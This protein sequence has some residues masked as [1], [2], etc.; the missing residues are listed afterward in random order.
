MCLIGMGPARMLSMSSTTTFDHGATIGNAE[1]AQAFARIATLLEER[2]T[3]EGRA[4]AY[5]RAAQELTRTTSDVPRIARAEGTKG[6]VKLRAIGPALAAEIME[7]VTAGRLRLLERLEEQADPERMLER[8]H[9]I[10]P[11]LAHRIADRLHLSTLEDLES[12]AHNGRLANV[13]GVGEARVAGARRL[14]TTELSRSAPGAEPL[15][16]PPVALLL[17]V[18]S[19]YR[20]QAADGRIKRIAPRRF[21]P[22]HRTWLAVLRLQRDGWHLSAMFSNTARAHR[23]DMTHDWVVIHYEREGKHGQCT[24]VTEYHGPDTG[25]RVIRG[26]E[27][28]CRAFRIA[29]PDPPRRFEVPVF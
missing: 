7:L 29:H 2:G 17:D 1:L 11:K 3:E 22:R 27:R 8:V 25:R 26:R 23:L 10:G 9:G 16:P 15:E 19:T 5:R 14:T 6:L 21:N 24:V 20:R 12:A 13:R 18:D 4:R 28:E